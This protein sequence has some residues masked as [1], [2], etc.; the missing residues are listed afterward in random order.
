M[1]KTLSRFE[2][3][4]QVMNL[5]RSRFTSPEWAWFEE[6]SNGTGG[7]SDTRA[8]GLAMNMWPSRGL[9]LVGFE[10]K[11]DRQDWRSEKKN[12]AKAEAIAKFCDRWWLVVDDLAVIGDHEVP[13]PW[14]I[15]VASGGKLKVHREASKLEASPLTRAF[16]A[17]L[18]RKSSADADAMRKTW[19]HPGV[20]TDRIN[21]GV[22][23]RLADRDA[24]DQDT[25]DRKRLERLEAWAEKIQEATGVYPCHDWDL[26]LIKEIV[27]RI[28]RG[29]YG[30]LSFGDRA[31]K[32]RDIAKNLEDADAMIA[33]ALEHVE[34]TK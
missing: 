31:Q 13:A 4:A 27:R 16:I 19:I 10:V 3:N 15:Y 33:K 23:K 1:T 14:G 28:R 34:Q 20:L 26:P 11:V 2:R 22:D 32:L 7:R 18:M 21:E 6:I 24:N 29:W 12:P 25:I 30:P 17:S 8:D 5:L 9:E